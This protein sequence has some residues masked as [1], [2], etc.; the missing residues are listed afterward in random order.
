MAK[1]PEQE[2]QYHNEFSKDLKNFFKYIT[3]LLCGTAEIK[4][5]INR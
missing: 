1:K 2:N 5:C 4:H 3:E